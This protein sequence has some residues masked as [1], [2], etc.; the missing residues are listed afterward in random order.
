MSDSLKIGVDL[1]D[2]CSVEIRKL[3]NTL[4]DKLTVF[5]VNGGF[6][7]DFFDFYFTK[8]SI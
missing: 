5:I 4:S 1:M 6:Q 3:Y 2:Q 7:M 8:S